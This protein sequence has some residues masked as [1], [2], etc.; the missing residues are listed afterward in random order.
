MR[1]KLKKWGFKFFAR[2]GISG[3]IYDFIVY[4]GAETFR[5]HQF[6]TCEGNMGF[7]AKIVIT[8]C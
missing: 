1:L 6:T 8:L 3:N 7:G 5:D 4:G 2:A